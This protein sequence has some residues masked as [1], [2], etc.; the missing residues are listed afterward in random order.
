M[1]YESKNLICSILRNKDLNINR[2]PLFIYFYSKSTYKILQFIEG[3]NIK[4]Q[5]LKKN[6]SQALKSLLRTS[7]KKTI[8][9][10][11]STQ[12]RNIAKLN[13]YE[14]HRNLSLDPSKREAFWE[15]Q[16]ADIHWF[17]KYNKV[18]DDSKAPLYRWFTGGET[19]VSYNCID[20]HVEQGRGESTAV[21]YE[22]AYSGAKS[23]ISYKELL[24]KVSK[25][26]RILSN[27]GVSKGDRVILYMPMIPEALIAMHACARIGAIHSVVFGGFAPEELAH[28]V[29]HAKPKLIVTSSCGIEPNRI[30][31][32]IPN[33]DK[34]LQD[35]GHP[36]MKRIIVQRDT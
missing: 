16:A 15:Q 1:I 33:V 17:K 19:N 24:E 7:Q 29:K 36:E 27:N 18:L 10:I 13:T 30:I 12:S 6:A 22:S 20:R 4:M 31:P 21:I 25:F 8:S 3:K 2:Y 5:Y 11:L 9:T 35:A 28:R 26:A 32:Y 34:A 23:K 14:E